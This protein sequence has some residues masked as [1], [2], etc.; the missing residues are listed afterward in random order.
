MG[1]AE[2]KYGALTPSMKL[3]A[4][5]SHCQLAQLPIEQATPWC[6]RVIARSLAQ[7]AL[8]GLFAN[9]EGKPR[10]ASNPKSSLPMPPDTT[11]PG[12][13]NSVIKWWVFSYNSPASRLYQVWVSSTSQ[14]Q[15]IRVGSRWGGICKMKS[16][17]N[18]IEIVCPIHFTLWMCG[19]RCKH[20][21]I[22]YLAC[23]RTPHC[24]LSTVTT[25]LS[26]SRSNIWAGC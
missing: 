17:S 24:Q 22:W 8:K 9:W 13:R 20:F 25:C 4:Q 2:Q 16:N 11:V 1:Q 14:S 10:F 21:I 19:K 23:E 12:R 7:L 18:E 3:L 15:I 6:G 5:V 26:L